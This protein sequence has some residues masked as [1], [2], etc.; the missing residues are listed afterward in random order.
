MLK[1]VSRVCVHLVDHR[2]HGH[3]LLHRRLRLGHGDGGRQVEDLPGDVDEL[4][5]AGLP[6]HHCRPGVRAARLALA[7]PRDLRPGRGRRRHLVLA[8]GVSA[9]ADSKVSAGRTA[10]GQF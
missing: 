1:Q 7:P 3:R 4:L 8:T 10:A 5:L 9:M 2:H 6:S